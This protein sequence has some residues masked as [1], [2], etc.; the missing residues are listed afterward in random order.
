MPENA[1][2][3]GSGAPQGGAAPKTATSAVL[4]ALICPHCRKGRLDAAGK[5]PGEPVTCAV[6]G[7]V[8]K[9]TLEMTLG[10]ERIFER[11]SRR[12]KAKR[13]FAELSDEEKIEFI[14]KQGALAQMYYYL[15]F[16]LGPKGMLGL[17]LGIFLL[18][19]TLFMTYQLTFGQ[20]T[21]DAAPWWVW[22]LAILGGGVLG[23]V[24]WFVHGTVMHYYQKRKAAAAAADPRRAGASSRRSAAVTVR[25]KAP[26]TATTRRAGPG[27]TSGKQ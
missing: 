24:G 2:P 20:K 4:R 3:S 18:F 12:D 11:Q 14:A 8:T 7:G 10:E 25:T 22:V 5:R 23:F 6:C 16:R 19:G 15:L 21:L 13:S 1:N 26:S 27:R 9:A 17:Y